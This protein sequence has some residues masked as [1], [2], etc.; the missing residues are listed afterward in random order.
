MPTDANFF[1]DLAYVLLA[2]GVGGAAARLARQP[3]IV[4]YVLGGILV[5]PFTPGPVVSE[6]HTFE[7]PA[8]FAAFEAASAAPA[9]GT[10]GRREPEGQ[11]PGVP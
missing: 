11:H 7:L 2:A 8:Q 10:A 5:S 6:L 1:R 3:V 4:G 9:E